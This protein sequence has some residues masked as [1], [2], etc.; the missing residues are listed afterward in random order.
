V[1][2]PDGQ[3]QQLGGSIQQYVYDEVRL[4]GVSHRCCCCCSSSCPAYGHA[5]IIMP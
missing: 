1:V 5:A 4:Q 2:G 3:L